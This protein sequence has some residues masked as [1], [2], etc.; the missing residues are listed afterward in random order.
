MR[1]TLHTTLLTALLSAAVL[2]APLFAQNQ[3]NK[4]MLAAYYPN[5]GQ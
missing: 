4:Q 3:E 1:K 2:A 5:W